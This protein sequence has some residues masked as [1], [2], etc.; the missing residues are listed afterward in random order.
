MLRS[1]LI[2][3]CLFGCG[4]PATSPTHPTPSKPAMTAL[5]FDPCAGI[6]PASVDCSDWAT[7]TKVNTTPFVSE[8][9][10]NVLVDVYVQ[11]EH[12]AAYTD[13]SQP[14]P[15]GIRVVKA[16]HAKD[17]SDKI[18]TLTVMGKMP[19]GYDPEH[20]DWFYGIYDPKGTKAMKQGRLEMCSDCH[21]QAA[22]RDFLFGVP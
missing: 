15:V 18:M 11:P 3:T 1:G 13:R 12:L 20:G 8:G 19:P 7:W 21:D 6:E 17:G 22:D 14:A 2:L 4:S 10:Q 5:D 16:Q 9:H